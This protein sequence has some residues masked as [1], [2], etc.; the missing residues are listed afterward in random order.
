[1]QC[2]S[3]V[4]QNP[5]LKNRLDTGFLFFLSLYF[6]VHIVVRVTLSESLDYDEAEQALLSQW[7]LAGY[8]EQPPLYTWVQ[9]YLISIFGDNVFSISLMKNGILWGTYLFT[10]MAGRLILQDDKKAVLATCALLFIP[11]IAWESQRDMTH[12]TLVVF[13]SAA[14]LFQLFSLAQKKTLLRYCFLGLYIGIGFLAKPNFALFLVTALLSFLVTAEGRSVLCDRKI[15]FSLA[16]PC[17][18]NGCYWLWMY[19]NQDIVFSATHKF[20]RAAEAFYLKGPLSLLRNSFLF[21]TPLWLF[22]LL[23]FPG[24]FLSPQRQTKAQQFGRRFMIRYMILSFLILLLIVVLFKVTYVKDRWLQPVLFAAPLCFFS[25]LAAE[26]ITSSRYK[27][28]L[29]LTGLVAVVVIITFSIRTLGASY[30]NIFCR[31]NYPFSDYANILKK[32]G[33]LQGLIISDNRFLAGNMLFALP[34][35]TAI[36][37]DYNFENL[38]L[39]KSYTSVLVIWKG[40]DNRPIPESLKNFLVEKYHINP[41]RYP[42]KYLEQEFKYSRGETVKLAV[43]QVPMSHLVQN[44]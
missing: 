24:S 11:Q 1:M 27:L 6:I 40:Y 21:L 5:P 13:A 7:L 35:S 33:F 19:N 12:T 42:I 17:A 20:K 39:A 37:P 3:A 31:L 14:T 9:H 18:M 2:P 15:F 22:L 10:Y 23:V 8:T 36:V 32:R 30:I 4:N 16:I 41:G 38:A 43:L 28:F 44:R 29:K 26:D 34:G 25:V